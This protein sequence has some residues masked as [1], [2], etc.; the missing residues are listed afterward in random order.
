LIK[1][2][3]FRW[4]FLA[5]LFIFTL[6]FPEII[7]TKK[8]SFVQLGDYFIDYVMA[9]LTTNFLYQGG[10]QLWDYFGQMPLAY[11][12]TT[13]GLFKLPG[14]L[15]AGVYY[16]LSPFADNSGQFFH[17]V[18]SLVYVL[19]LLGIRTLGIYLLLTMFTKE[20]W[21]QAFGTVI[22]S[23]FFT[24][25]ALVL[26]TFY[27]S[28]FPLI[29][30]IILRAI[31]EGRL[32]YVGAAILFFGISLSNGVIHTCY[33]YLGVH[34]FIVSSLLW[35][36][37]HSRGRIDV[38]S[39]ASWFTKYR[40]QILGILA[41][42][43]LMVAPY[44][45]IKL[46]C[47]KDV[48]FNSMDSRV[49]DFWGINN[50]FKNLPLG[51]SPHQDLFRRMLDFQFTPPE[52]SYFLGYSVFFLSALGVVMH[53]DSRKW[54]FVL[55]IL[56]IW[57]I[58][59]PREG[60]SLGLIAHWINALT[61]PLKTLVRSYHVSTISMLPYLFMPLVI[62]GAQA[63]YDI[64][65]GKAPEEGSRRKFILVTLVM[66]GFALSS[67]PYLPAIVKI[68][69][70]LAWLLSTGALFLSVKRP[71]FIYCL[72]AL[73]LLDGLLALHQVRHYIYELRIIRP[74]L[75]EQLPQVGLVNFD[76]RNPKITPLSESF[77]LDKETLDPYMSIDLS[78][79]YHRFINMGSKFRTS[80][81]HRPRHISY[82]QWSEDRAMQDYLSKQGDLI[83]FS[84]DGIN[85]SQTESQWEYAL[86]GTISDGS[87]NFTYDGQTVFLSL[88][89]NPN[90][91]DYLATALHGKNIK[92]L[93]ETPE[94][95]LIEFF[96]IPGELTH[97]LTFDVQNIK[98]GYAKAAFPRELFV[99]GTK[100]A[101]ILR[102]NKEGVEQVWRHQFDH[103]GINFQ[104]PKD[105]WMMLL[106]PYDPKW[107]I[108]ID[109]ERTAFERVNKSFIRVPVK[110]GEHKVL[111]EY[112]PSSA[113]RWL[114][115]I[116]VL[117][118]SFSFFGL[119]IWCLR[120]R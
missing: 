100:Y 109:G 35:L 117:T 120:R 80:D 10:I 41:L 38:K 69:V 74:H 47:L 61:N 93:I 36:L 83:F 85:A 1:N 98:E 96:P 31:T 7:L 21:M 59:H 20:R 23:V 55:S 102:H 49:K 46:F 33:L 90:F 104:A 64:L 28:F 107:Q 88:P 114:L 95:K 108:T 110:A 70:I 2:F 79:N 99:T 18:F 14:I 60:V 29:M 81:S 76:Y 32:A 86:A 87:S 105:G 71:Q 16:V 101:L 57:M 111:I 51:L 63:A 48:D 27:Q 82:S 67:L 73:F 17:Q 52:A 6:C 84:A 5:T 19:T 97:P 42:F 58:N 113:L 34:F 75:V 43:I 44:V 118:A 40:L 116:S 37:I 115:L 54:I 9:S 53:K 39:A 11:Y 24:T 8:V 62:M 65:Q 112:W 3:R 26:G 13:L 15:T 72:A 50:Y 119:C 45:Y 89:L 12:Y 94:K 22:F 30:Y 103:L 25:P 78:N 66:G 77:I 4:I 68:Y 106:Y 56:F 92:F 91:P